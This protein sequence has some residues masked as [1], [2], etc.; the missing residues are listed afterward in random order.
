MVTQDRNINAAQ[1]DTN[2]I[3]EGFRTAVVS[4]LV[5]RRDYGADLSSYFSA[6]AV[7][8][9]NFRVQGKT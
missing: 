2:V 8:L 4:A 7:E 6:G 5:S 1:Q 3:S 9:V